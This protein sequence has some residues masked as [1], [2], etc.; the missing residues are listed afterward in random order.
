MREISATCATGVF[1][2]GELFWT[3]GCVQSE[4]ETVTRVAAQV[5]ELCAPK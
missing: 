2:D 1:V 4:A 3:D 5:A